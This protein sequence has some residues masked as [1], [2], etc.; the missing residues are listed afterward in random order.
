[1]TSLKANFLFA[2]AGV[3]VPVVIICGEF[4]CLADGDRFDRVCWNLDNLLC[5]Y[6]VIT[7]AVSWYNDPDMFKTRKFTLKN[8]LSMILAI[9]SCFTAMRFE[10]L[11]KSIYQHCINLVTAVI[12]L[13]SLIIV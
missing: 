4:R 7:C 13:I 9:L 6:G 8:I 5:V 3:F 2:V 1:M 10:G 11:D 12:N